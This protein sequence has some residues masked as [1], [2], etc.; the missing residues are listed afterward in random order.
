MAE[1][2]WQERKDGDQIFYLQSIG[3]YL[4]IY[5]IKNNT[6]VNITIYSTNQLSNTW[7]VITV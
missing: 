6:S 7:T 4:Y 5:N 3:D 2:M 1:K